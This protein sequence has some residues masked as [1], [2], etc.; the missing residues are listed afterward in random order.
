MIRIQKTS[1]SLLPASPPSFLP[2]IRIVLALACGASVASAAPIATKLSSSRLPTRTDSGATFQPPLDWKAD[3]KKARITFTAPEGDL[4]VTLFETDAPDAA[5][6]E[7]QTLA[8]IAPDGPRR[9]VRQRTDLAARVGWEQ[10]HHVV[11]ETS[12]NEKRFEEMWLFRKGARFTVVLLQGATATADRRGSQLATLVGTL[13]PPGY[14][15]ESFAHK[16]PRPLDDARIAELI[17]FLKSAQQLLDIPGLGFALFTK[18]RVLYEGGFGV[19]K[20]GSPAP[21]SPDTRFLVASN[22]KPMVTLLLAKLVD[23]KKIAWHTPVV[24]ILPQFR[25]GSVET[26]NRV[27]IRHLVCACTGL[28]RQDL[29]WTFEFAQVTPLQTLTT[30]GSMTPTSKLGELFQYSNPLVAAA[31]WVAGHVA[32]PDLPLGA[33]FDRAMDDR[34]FRP[35]GMTTTFD[36]DV[37]FAGDFA[38]PHARDV[39]D[40]KTRL[41]SIDFNR[42]ITALRPAGGAWASVRDLRK[43]A[44]LELGRGVLPNGQR[45]LGEAALL[46]RR[47]PTIAVSQT[48]SYGMGL[49]L[50]TRSDVRVIRHG[51]SMLGYKSDFVLLPDLDLGFVFVTNA[52]SGWLLRRPLLR[53]L[54]EILFD[55]ALEATEDLAVANREELATLAT[56]RERLVVPPPQPIVDALARAYV[57][58][59]LGKIT[60]R[61][62]DSGRARVFLDVGE[63]QSEVGARKNDDGTTSLRTVDP[64]LDYDFVIGRHDGAPTLTIRDDQHEYRF[65]AVH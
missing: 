3:V 63:W 64:G 61:R 47:K 4:V 53:R 44:Q 40:G 22:T 2:A 37:A 15:A 54:L 33:A 36:P 41:A 14:K 43:L 48:T 59:T 39:R 12:P 62:E 20:V 11:Y 16:K 24:T 57:H 60:I 42:S 6:A 52:D 25:L 5:T 34:V 26:T 49:M 17:T 32:F 21:V 7:T 10:R 65:D 31:G 27:L 46:E 13:F 55:G 9:A 29:E 45:L 38:A 8:A 1:D 18:D 56:D 50:E 35:L 30:L 58:S 51:G 28:P 19:Q 23:E